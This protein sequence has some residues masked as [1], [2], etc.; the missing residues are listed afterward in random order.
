M[1]AEKVLFAEDFT[2][3]LNQTAVFTGD[4]LEYRWASGDILVHGRLTATF[5]PPPA[6]QR[7]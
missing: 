6:D 4:S 7:R 2:F 5:S 3:T 1:N